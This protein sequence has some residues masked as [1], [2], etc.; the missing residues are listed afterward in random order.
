MNVLVCRRKSKSC[1]LLARL[2]GCQEWPLFSCYEKHDGDDVGNSIRL[3]LRVGRR[4][5]LHLETGR[6]DRNGIDEK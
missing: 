1:C 2:E 3:F 5:L 4:A 6:V